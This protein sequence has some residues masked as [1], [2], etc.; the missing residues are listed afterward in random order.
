MALIPSWRTG[1][2]TARGLGALGVMG[3]VACVLAV[4]YNICTD[5][6]RGPPL[7]NAL[8]WSGH[9]GYTTLRIEASSYFAACDPNNIVWPTNS[10]AVVEVT[11]Q[12]FTPR[13]PIAN[14]FCWE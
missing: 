12:D 10:F 3:P 8:M 4:A 13:A 1:V 7:S 11:E 6:G 5:Q 2:V 14:R 9:P